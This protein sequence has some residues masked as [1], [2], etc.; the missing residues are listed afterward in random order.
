MAMLC[1]CIELY[2]YYRKTFYMLEKSHNCMHI[3]QLKNKST[4]EF[5]ICYSLHNPININYDK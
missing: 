4:E 5:L 1:K 3:L 2:L